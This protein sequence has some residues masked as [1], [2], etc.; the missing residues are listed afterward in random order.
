MQYDTAVVIGRFEPAH[1]AHIRL[2]KEARSRAH[3]VIVIIGSSFLPRTYKNPFTFAERKAMLE[4]S[5]GDT[6]GIIIVPNTDSMYDNTAWSVRIQD[7]VDDYRSGATV[8]LVGHNKDAT[9]W[10]LDSFP[11]WDFINI[12]LS[13]QLSASDIR[14]LYFRERPNLNFIKSVVPTPVLEYMQR[15][16]L[17]DA[18]E[19]V[20]QERLHILKYRQQF[21][22]LQFEPIFVT[23]DAVVIQCGHVL[24]VTRGAEP[25]KGLLAFPGGFVNASTDRSVEDA[26]IRELK[27]ETGIKVPVPALRGN[28]KESRVFD[29]IDRSSRGRVI[30]HAY[31]I[32]L[33]DG[34]L[35]KVRGM[36]DAAKAQWIPIGSL[37]SEQLFE[38]H[39]DILQYFVGGLT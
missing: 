12:P 35:P 7:I 30:T 31:K 25:G 28:I 27:E 18:Y 8:A 10:Y 33:P 20:L 26:A 36:D 5:L 29:A 16:M 32:V 15:F 1:N 14:D 13:E 17:T 38:D 19:T 3:Q 24:M 22:H 23:A 11:Q 37:T 2:I 21:S 6:Q 34:P 39:W 9:T 4:S